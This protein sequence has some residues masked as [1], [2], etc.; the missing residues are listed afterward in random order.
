MHFVIVS[1]SAV[2]NPKP[3]TQNP[4]P[5]TPKTKPY[6][7]LRCTDWFVRSLADWA[8]LKGLGFRA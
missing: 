2:R 5:Q 8:Q 4:K 1:A 3:K 6:K 7:A